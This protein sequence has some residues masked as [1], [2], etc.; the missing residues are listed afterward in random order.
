MQKKCLDG[1]VL[2]ERREP[3]LELGVRGG[4]VGHGAPFALV[5]G[6]VGQELVAAAA[7]VMSW[8]AMRG[9]RATL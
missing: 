4:D 3:V 9:N 5:D 8:G 2:A 7:C 1:R 6:G